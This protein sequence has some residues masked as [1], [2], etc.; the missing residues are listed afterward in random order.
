MRTIELYSQARE[1]EL[2][3]DKMV[4]SINRRRGENPVGSLNRAIKMALDLLQATTDLRNEIEG[5]VGVEAID[6]AAKPETAEDPGR[7][8][9]LLR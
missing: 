4:A 6:E 3:V 1:L 2:T 5:V 9:A 7:L 8:L